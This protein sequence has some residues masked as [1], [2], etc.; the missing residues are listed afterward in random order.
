MET[1]NQ[2]KLLEADHKIKAATVAAELWER[3]S[4]SGSCFAGFQPEKQVELPVLFS[5]ETKPEVVKEEKQASDSSI[6]NR[7]SSEAQVTD[8][9]SSS[10]CE[11][12][13]KTEALNHEPEVSDLCRVAAVLKAGMELPRPQL[14]YFD[15]DPLMYTRFMISFDEN[16]G[17]RVDS[18]SVKLNYLIQYC[19]KEAHAMIAFCIG[20]DSPEGYRRAR[21]LLLERYGRPIII[22][23]AYVDKLSHWPY[24]KSDDTDGLI[25]LAQALEECLVTL[26]HLGYF[27]D[28]NNF[29]N[30]LNIIKRLP[31]ALQS[32]WRRHAAKIERNGEEPRFCHLV[33]FVK[34]EAYIG[35]TMFGRVLGPRKDRDTQKRRSKSPTTR[36]RASTHAT[37]VAP[38]NERKA[39]PRSP[40]KQGCPLCSKSHDLGNCDVF[41]RKTFVE[42]RKFLRQVRL[43]D[44]CFVKGHI[45][46]TCSLPNSCTI[47]GCRGK[48]HNLLHWTEWKTSSTAPV[49]E[50]STQAS[51]EKPSSSNATVTW[52]CMSTHAE[53]VY[54]NIVPVKVTASNGRK[55]ETYA[56]LDQGSTTTLCDKRLIEQLDVGGRKTT[57]SLTTVSDRSQRREGLAVD[58]TVASLDGKQ[59]VR[60]NDVLS[61]DS[62][63]VSPNRIPEGSLWRWPHLRNLEFP[64][65]PHG[66]VMLLIGANVP[67]VFWIN[68]ER[69]GGRKEPS[70]V[71]S[72]LGWSLVGPCRSNGSRSSQIRV[73]FVTSQDETLHQQIKCMWESDFGQTALSPGTT[74]SKEDR[75]ALKQM[76][77]SVKCH[78]GHYQL[79]LPWRPGAPNLP[80]N[81]AMAMKRLS[82]LKRRL[83][84]DSQL[85]EK[86]KQTLDTYLN[87]G[88]ARRLK[89]D[90]KEPEDGAVWYLPHH[91]VVHPQKPGKVRVVFDC[92]ARYH[93]ISLND[94][95]LQ[96]P[97]LL[98]SLFGTLVRFR[99]EPVAFVAD[100]EAMFHQ[101][102]V[103]PIDASAL[104]FVWWP[105]GDLSR[106]PVDYQMLVH[107]FGAASSPCCAG[108]CL[109][110]TAED[111]KE[112]FSSEAVSTVKQNF[113]V[114]DCLKSVRNEDDAIKLAGELR[115]L[116]QLGGFRLRKWV[117]N[118]ERVLSSVPTEDRSVQSIILN[119]DVKHMERVLGV[120]WNFRSDVFEFDVK[121]KKKPVTRR[122]ILSVVSSLF[123]PLG[124]VAP[125]ILH[126]RKLLQELCKENYGWDQEVPPDIEKRWNAW[127]SELP[128]LSE[129]KIKRCFQTTGLEV[130]TH[131][132]HHFADASSCGYGT[133]AY[134]RTMDEQGNVHCSFVTGK[135][136]LAPLKMVSIPRLE[137]TAA[138]LAVKM[139]QVLRQELD[140]DIGRS[141]FWTDSTAVLQSIYNVNKR[142]C[143]FFANRL[144]KIE[145]GSDASQW[146]HVP[147]A[148]NP[149]DD[150]SR[151]CTV[152]AFLQNKRWFTGP[153]FLGSDER[154]WPTNP[155]NTKDVPEEYLN[156]K[157]KKML[158]VHVAE[159]QCLF[160]DLICRYSSWKKLKKAV[161]WLQRFVDYLRSKKNQHLS[162]RLTVAD[163]ESAELAIVK[164]VQGRQFSD[165]IEALCKCE[166]LDRTGKKKVMKKLPSKAL[167]RLNPVLIGGVLR[168]GGRL[169]RA[170]IPFEI[171]HPMILPNAHHITTLIIRETHANVCHSG[172]SHTWA[173]VRQRYWIVRGGVAVRRILGNCV[174]CRRRNASVSK[175]MMADLPVERTTPG[176]P[177][178]SSVGVDYFGPD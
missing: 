29:E 173:I 70:A 50:A 1:E 125:V 63:P 167:H 135:A 13:P 87:E 52:T 178:F 22:A 45:A 163:L 144:A 17:R 71:R 5:P 101:V 53:S 23:R 97:D 116:L 91:P 88:Y 130:K 84:T 107:I 33:E 122:G 47:G 73:N 55:L 25:E 139:D 129:I 174:F 3:T 164:Y 126:A 138:T 100:V 149:A 103:D 54:L 21:E 96:G 7:S 141:V 64:V 75:Y 89:C 90:D 41:K 157:P 119:V 121:V 102:K 15:G 2:L 148:L 168:V 140:L 111:N 114:D 62:L 30:M 56:F 6:I 77:S 132:L 94:Q 81:R 136:R 31:F 10:R 8:I 76:E 12:K 44:N 85:Y 124:F 112:K 160:D 93:N 113:Y 83:E 106:E 37:S 61:V 146:K 117:S 35:T 134:L 11:P 161:A 175:Q 176:E 169:E 78:D 127:I 68:D 177:P 16:I 26:T 118:S 57:Y 171:K 159:E 92:A 108:Y 82:Y 51:E 48:H 65:L 165:E 137:L 60:L 38:G 72:M 143:T 151:G 86:Y 99:Q 110:K 95:L 19:R 43:C 145:E 32:Q 152:K 69:R 18:D 74:L 34:K 123:D 24:L 115:E 49:R 105:E 104:R 40:Q 155:V 153:S 98:N 59:S 156:M 20:L 147:T 166:D 39:E 172:M 4:S 80:N 36:T 27:A 158:A 42:R 109:Q 154:H 150:A 170:P 66:E 79:R 162:K 120:L 142:F 67:E 131:E 14:L 128:G 46:R 58:L 133:V 28:I 9:P